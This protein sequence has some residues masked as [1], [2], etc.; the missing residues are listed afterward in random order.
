MLRHAL[1]AIVAVLA[2]AA[3]AAAQVIYGP[4]RPMANTLVHTD[5]GGNLG[6]TGNVVCTSGC[7]GGTTDT[8]DG[9]VAA[10][11]STGLS[12]N[13][14]YL[15]N[16]STWARMPGDVTSGL[17]VQ[18]SDVTQTHNT[19][20]NPLKSIQIG[21]AN[22]DGGTYR[23]IGASN[24]DPGANDVGLFVRNISGLGSAGSAAPTLLHVIAGRDPVTNGIRQVDSLASAPTGTE[25]GVIT[26]PILPVTAATSTKQS[27]GSQKTQIV[28]GSGN[29]IES[30]T[31]TPAPG[32]RGLVIWAKQ[33]SAWLTDAVGN[34]A[35]GTADSGNPVK[36]GCRAR[37]TIAAVAADARVDLYCDTFGRPQVVNV[38][39]YTTQT[40][41]APAT[42]SA[43]V[44]SAQAVAANASRKGIII[45]NVSSA[46]VCLGIASA[47]VIDSGICLQPDAALSLLNGGIEG[48]PTGAINAIAA[49][50]A[51]SI[52][53]QEFQ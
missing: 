8:D 28:D 43:G 45:V 22:T 14:S 41:N 13:L 33:G 31:S 38:P 39:T 3:P 29:V 47:A 11:Q 23:H 26:R 24:A 49:S 6:I 32:A 4:L 7:A 53:I 12:I 46:K 44:A 40:A 16:G 2:C 17:K 21:G 36:V 10:G 30:A 50:A 5:S 37:G 25:N 19:I 9:S 42:F 35:H 18:L 20:A 51:S 34:V 52:S 48:V 1:A 27:D 15:W